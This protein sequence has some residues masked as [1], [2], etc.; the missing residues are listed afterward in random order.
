MSENKEIN[1][2][3]VVAYLNNAFSKA[4]K[5]LGFKNIKGTKLYDYQVEFMYLIDSIQ[6]DPSYM[7]PKAIARANSLIDEVCN[8]VSETV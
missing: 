4:T 6:R 5:P 2:P 3:Q 7:A 8:E 1:I